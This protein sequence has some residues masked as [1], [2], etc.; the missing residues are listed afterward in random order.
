MSYR[1]NLKKCSRCGEVAEHGPNRSARNGLQGWCRSC[2]NANSLRR[3][4]EVLAEL[5]QKH[6]PCIDCG[7]TENLEFDHID[8]STK[9]CNPT[10]W[11]SAPAKR[12]AEIAM[13]VVRCHN[14]HL[15]RSQADGH[16]YWDD[17]GRDVAGRFAAAA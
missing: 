12:D 14:C 13:C 3:R 11:W 16:L 4:N 2:S 5:F 1:W 6:G 8:P 17:R 15:R 9:T 7:S 10:Q